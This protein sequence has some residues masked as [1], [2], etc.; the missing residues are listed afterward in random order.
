MFRGLI[1]LATLLTGCVNGEAKQ[2]RLVKLPPLPSEYISPLEKDCVWEIF[3]E[4]V[5]NRQTQRLKFRYQN[6][7][8]FRENKLWIKKG[9]ILQYQLT[10][11]YIDKKPAMEFAVLR[12][13][14][15]GSLAP[16]DFIESQLSKDA[17]ESGLCDIV[18]ITPGLWTIDSK[19]EIPFPNLDEVKLWTRPD[20]PCGNYVSHLRHDDRGEVYVFNQGIA[21]KIGGIGVGQII[22]LNSLIYEKRG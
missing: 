15:S 18:E 4:A 9:D 17:L 5:F 7:K 1:L 11:D 2:P 10:I 3:D 14:K 8:P 21:F 19:F 13:Y 20:D 22:D 6:C 12:L 16:Q